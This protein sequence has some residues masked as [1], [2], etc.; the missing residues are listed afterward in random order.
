MDENP[1]LGGYFHY[2]FS[3]AAR[4]NNVIY[5]A[6]VSVAGSA[7]DR[8]CELMQQ[9]VGITKIRQIANNKGL[10]VA[11]VVYGKDHIQKEHFGRKNYKPKYLKTQDSATGKM[12]ALP[13]GLPGFDVENPNDLRLHLMGHSMGALTS[14][15]FQYMLEQSKF[16]YKTPSGRLVKSITCFAG[17]INGSLAPMNH[18]G[19]WCP[20]ERKINF[21]PYSKFIN[22][23][24]MTIWAQNLFRS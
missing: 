18:G 23:F 3:E 17:A 14:R 11:E 24:K 6:D 12:Y 19:Q 9:I 7:H 5:E 10:S 13:D 1:I 2:A 15:H 21:N 4:E 20:S 16:E 22:A 8:A